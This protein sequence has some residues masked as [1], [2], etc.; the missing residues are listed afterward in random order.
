MDIQD[1]GSFINFHPKEYYRRNWYVWAQV[2]GGEII[3]LF[4]SNSNLYGPPE[5]GFTPAECTTD[6]RRHALCFIQ[7]SIQAWQELDE[8]D[9]VLIEDW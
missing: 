4:L 6:L 9:P 3:F 2:E 5:K 1:F 8:D 7:E